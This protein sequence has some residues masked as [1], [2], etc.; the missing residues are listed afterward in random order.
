M[1]LFKIIAVFTLSSITVFS[2]VKLPQQSLHAG[3][4]AVIPLTTEINAVYF[5]NNP[6]SD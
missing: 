4:I 1:N 2:L 6:C 3:N 5:D